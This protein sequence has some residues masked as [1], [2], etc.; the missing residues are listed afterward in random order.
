MRIERVEVGS[1]VRTRD[2]LTGRGPFI[3]A[4][5]CLF[6]GIHRCVPGK[7][8]LLSDLANPPVGE[9]CM[10][11]Q[12]SVYGGHCQGESS[13]HLCAPAALVAA[14]EGR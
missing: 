1:V 11:G 7:L 2:G 6:A 4:R 5:G 9:Y 12:R 8:V 14:G 13:A 10:A 3:D